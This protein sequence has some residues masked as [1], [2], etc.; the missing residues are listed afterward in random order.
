MKVYI[1]G[2]YQTKFGE[3]WDKSLE[4]LIFESVKFALKDA[5][6]DIKN[7][8]VIYIGNMLASQI[9]NQ[10][11]LNSLVSEIFNINIPI[12]RVESACASGSVAVNQA[13][14]V[15]KSNLYKNALVIG[16]EKMTDI[17]SKKISRFLMS[18]ASS[19]ERLS[20][21][22][23]AGL[24][25]L[26]ASKYFSDYK[27]TSRQLADVSI[28]NHFHASLNE[29]SQFPFK[30]TLDKYN[31]SPIIASPLNLFDC[32]PISDG[33]CTILLSTE[34]QKNSV[35]IVASKVATDSISLDKR[36]NI[37]EFKSTKIAALNSFKEAGIERKDVD[38]LEVHDCFTIA[39]I[40]ALEDLGFYKKGEGYRSSKEKDSYYY[41]KLPVNTSGGLKACGHPVAA[42]GVKQVLELFNQINGRCSAR[43]VKNAKVGLAQNIGGTG[44]TAVVNILKK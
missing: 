1:K 24:Y 38:L 31:N 43:Q 3:L 15:L 33:A 19:S 16:V 41:G 26:I 23:F 39:E 44:G 40:I 8:E 20:G 11:H 10:N 4:D 36:E 25:A 30:I 14:T 35:E 42:T 17:P 29:K 27:I 28:K 7:V 22:T 37:C 34:K 5:N 21:I 12:I 18:A 2:G 6:F 13:Y 32:S 9:Y